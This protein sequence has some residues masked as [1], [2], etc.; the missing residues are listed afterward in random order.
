[1]IL[2]FVGLNYHHYNPKPLEEQGHRNRTSSSPSS[3]TANLTSPFANRAFLMFKWFRQPA[4]PSTSL[5]WFLVDQR[6]TNHFADSQKQDFD[7]QI[8]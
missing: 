4:R 3:G 5:A 2:H 7:Y 6:R 1:M 8:N